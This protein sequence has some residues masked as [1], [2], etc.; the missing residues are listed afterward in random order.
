MNN[1][2]QKYKELFIS[3]AKEHLDN[4]DKYLIEFEKNPKDLEVCKN[5]MRFAH[6]LKGIAASVGFG[7]VSNLAHSFEGMVENIKNG[8]VTGGFNL[9]FGAVDELRSLVVNIDNIGDAK[10]INPLVDDVGELEKS[11]K[12]TD[13]SII[14]NPDS[15]DLGN[16]IKV[17]IERLDKILGFV[18]E[19][20]MVRL[21]IEKILKEQQI[22]E[23]LKSALKNNSRIVDFLQSEVLLLRLNPIGDVFNRFPRMVRDLAKNQNKQIDLVLS[24][25]EIE[26]DK[27]ILDNL[28]EP[29]VHLLRNSVDH[30]IKSKGTIN[31]KAKRDK[32]RIIITVEDNGEGIDWDK[33]KAKK[34]KAKSVLS[35]EDF[36]FSGI[37]T[38]ETV[39]EISGRGVGLIAVKKKLDSFGGKI[40]IESKKGEG[41][42]FNLSIP[43][44]MAVVKAIIL[45]SD[46]HKFALPITN[47]E[48][49]IQIKNVE[50]H[51]NAGEDF[52]ILENENIPLIDVAKLI[53]SNETNNNKKWNKEVV[54]ISKIKN[55]KVGLIFEKIISEQNIIVKSLDENMRELLYFSATTILENGEAIPIIDINSFTKFI[56]K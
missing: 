15:F 4:M 7:E 51:I 31:L 50:E 35:D 54:V 24:G 9:L 41:T 27:T 3:E 52:I 5:L 40:S 43:I 55:E 21:S 29:L 39:T 47:I 38:S 10:K 48:R 17:K 45:E 13:K 44:S 46:S 37:S 11:D 22:D 16:E 34:E 53:N 30:G 56:K 20:M 2:N 33:V 12:T 42:A 19:L 32:D 18:S 49:L 8:L 25:E 1:I 6:T 36:M 26:V 28:G 23:T 14:A